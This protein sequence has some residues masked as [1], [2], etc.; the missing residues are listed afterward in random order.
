MTRRLWTGG[1]LTLALAATLVACSSGTTGPAQDDRAAGVTTQTGSPRFD[2]RI[3]SVVGPEGA[4]GDG[5]LGGVWIALPPDFDDRP[6]HGVGLVIWAS[7]EIV[8][9]EADGTLRRG[10][11]SDLAAGKRVRAWT[12]DAEYLSLPPAYDAT[13]VEIG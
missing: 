11:L 4:P 6:G 10:S 7:T 8:V 12:T 2:G 3:I 5:D 9:R 13:R 1:A